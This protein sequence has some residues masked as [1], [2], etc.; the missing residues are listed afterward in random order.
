MVK[1]VTERFRCDRCDKV[2]ARYAIA[3]TDATLLLDRCETHAKKIEALRDE[4]GEWVS[5]TPTHKAVFKK[6]SLAELKLALQK[7]E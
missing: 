2:G 7:D 1:E 6:T 4:P 5:N 3:F